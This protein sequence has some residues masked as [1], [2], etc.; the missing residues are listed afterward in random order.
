MTKRSYDSP[1][2]REAAEAT[3]RRVVDA[4]REVMLE[5]GY[6]RASVSAIAARAGVAVQTVYAAAPGGKAGLGRLVYDVTLA[7]DHE[8]VPQ[9]ERPA[10]LAIVDEPDPVRKLELF[11]AMAREVNVR[12]APVHALL[13]AAAVSH[14]D[15]QEL[16]DR[17][18][19]QR[20]TGSRGP[21][22]HLAELGLLRPG[23]TVERAA[24]GFYVLTSA[25]VFADL[26]ERCG[27]SGDEYERWLADTLVATMLAPDVA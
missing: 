7:G 22:A 24:D 23:L 11:A 20:R 10:V 19:Q 3:R 12:I 17:A 9:A 4:A 6:A 8:P 15:A 21:A 26:V 5:R 25:T 2:R 27:W 1:A 13:R 14:D 18:E 16:L